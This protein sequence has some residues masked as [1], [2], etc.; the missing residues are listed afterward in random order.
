MLSNYWGCEWPSDDCREGMAGGKGGSV[1]YRVT[2][3]YTNKRGYVCAG[4]LRVQPPT[5]SE[6]TVETQNMVDQRCCHRS[7]HARSLARLLQLVNSSS[8]T[9][10]GV[11]W[12]R[13]FKPLAAI[14]ISTVSAHS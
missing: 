1:Q 11:R 6:Y 2:R 12:R 3:P 13:A 8:D 5:Y 9:G 7:C 10:Q 14:S 4:V